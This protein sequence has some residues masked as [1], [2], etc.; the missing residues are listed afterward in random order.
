LICSSARQGRDAERENLKAKR[1]GKERKISQKEV[2]KEAYERRHYGRNEGK[3]ERMAQL[4]KEINFIL[5]LLHWFG[6]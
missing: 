3:E 1:K 5:N 6:A 2:K 4:R